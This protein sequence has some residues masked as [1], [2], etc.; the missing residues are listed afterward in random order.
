MMKEPKALIAFATRWGSRFG[1]I[2]S[3]NSDLLIAFSAAFYSNA[4]TICVVLY[5]TP[6]ERE[7][8]RREQV[9][10]VQLELPDVDAFGPAFEATVWQGLQA[11]NVH[12]S[13]DQT[14]WLGHDRIT[15]EI[16]LAAAK[17][18]GG[19][20]ALIHHMSYGHYEAFS[21]SSALADTK[22]REQR[23]LFGQANVDLAVGPLLRDALAD[24]L[25]GKTVAMLV[26]GLPEIAMQGTPRTF[27]AFLSGRLSE[28]ARKI[29]QAHLGV[30]AFGEAIRRCD[31]EPGLPDAL[32]GI[33]EPRLVL[34]GVDFEN[35]DNKSDPHAEQALKSFAERYAKRA[36]ALNALPFTTD[37]NMLFD[38]LR[39]AS[40]AMMPSWHEGFG[41]VAWE[42]IGAG[43]PLIV[44]AKS[45]VYRLLKDLDDGLYTSWVTAIDIAG[46]SEHPF[47]QKRDCD[48]LA[49]ALTQI[50]KDPNG[51]RN[52]AAQ[53]REALSSKFTWAKC[54]RQLADAFSW[55]FPEAEIQVVPT[56]AA[57]A[58]TH[59]AT[60]NLNAHPYSGFLDLPSPTW[61]LNPGLSDSQLLRAE[62]VVIPFD[63]NR[64]GYLQMQLDWA[65]SREYPIAVR[66]LTGQGGVGKTRL[67]I[68][69]CQRLE[70]DG[71][72]TGFL[73]SECDT[74]SA[75]ALGREMGALG[76]DFCVVLDY[77][78]TRQPLLLALLKALLAA[79]PKALVRVLLLARDGGE[80]WNLLPAK[81]PACEALLDGYASSGPFALPHLHH[82]EADREQAYR[83]ALH[84][85]AEVL[86]VSPPDS[87]P[88]LSEAHFAHPLYIQMAALMALR[89]ER[90]RSAEALPRAL[91]NHERRYWHKAISAKEEASGDDESHAALL[92][93]LATLSNGIVTERAIE[94]VWQEAGADRTLLKP[95]FRTLAP[96]Y[97]G[98]QGLQGLRPDL[99]GE[100]L[101]AQ[102]L[103]SSRGADLIN[104]VLSRGD[105]SLRHSSLT[106]LARVLRNR[107]EIAG[108][109]EDALSRN[110]LTCIDDLIA[111]CI[112]TPSPLPHLV[113]R[114]FGRLERQQRWQASGM[115]AKWLEFEVLPLAGLAVQIGET[116]LE[117]AKSKLTRRTLETESEYATALLNLSIDYYRD[118]NSG[119]ALAAAR[120]ALEIRKKLAHAKPERFE[121]DLAVSLG[122]CASHLSAQGL[123]DEALAA[124]RQALEIHKKLARAKPERFEPD[125]ATSLN[126]F[127][128]RLADHGVDDQALAAAKQALEIY[129][130]LAKA[131]PERF[132]P[133]M[134][135]SLNN[136][137]SRLADQGLHDQ[138]LAA[139]KQALDIHEKLAKAKPERFGPDLAMSLSNYASHLSDQG[140]H[141]QALAAAKQALEI[142]E[143]LAEANP[144]R[145]EPDLATSL[146]NYANHLS[147]QGLY[148][149]A[150]AAAKQALEIRE[151]LAKAKPERFEPDLAMSLINCANRFGD[152]G[153]YDEALAAAKQAFEIYQIRAKSSPTRYLYDQERTRLICVFWNWL[154]KQAPMHEALAMPLPEVPFSRDKAALA[155]QWGALSVLHEAETPRAKFA[156]EESL[157][158][159][160]ILD[161]GQKNGWENSYFVIVALSE[162][163]FGPDAAPEGWRT[164]W[165]RCRERMQGQPPHWMIDVA[166]RLTFEF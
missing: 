106:V 144:E 128:N 17:V 99:L 140:L 101:V 83:L 113:E 130:K 118:G 103:L 12:P 40:V 127:S 56:A 109:M 47:F 86:A 150:L 38:D 64:E 89:G 162:S 136:Y 67:A 155:F 138:A 43:V 119:S 98:R 151:K 141:D 32:R 36:F 115:V 102:T 6:E 1:G 82:S 163:R 54:A 69:L 51:Y 22:E 25:G 78:E 33:N 13:P 39:G 157:R 94:S 148:H 31:E 139:A 77:A 81:D 142:R 41:L 165:M 160:S 96:L 8:A 134:A 146:S 21:E 143:K 55:N 9:Q 10:L 164:Q 116:S 120:Q 122:N 97:P 4:K 95:I 5:A 88:D 90:P 24:M 26:P 2:N 7:M 63:Q 72:Q 145:F 18:R 58:P 48:T 16:A 135:M 30:A 65:R 3:F 59:T 79:R 166:H 129:T 152:Q 74:K 104:A 114:A 37:R 147:D 156:I 27:K 92:M 112:Q 91:V 110:F 76:I 105:G 84:T 68:E 52:R 161:L 158:Q 149:A 29:K 49:Q 154:G 125:L 131:K 159:W 28:D 121:P 85:F 46:S 80:W 11:E 44:S 34:R 15:G 133:D 107:P 20:S 23:Q 124:A 132:E 19:K 42:A 61:H 75:L 66:L 35:S 71:W 153:L 137:A 14:V 117:K 60:G 100:A 70:T 126:N 108:T 45:G 93:T 53:L 62:E 111:V 73:R 123:D 87:Q 50:A 57:V